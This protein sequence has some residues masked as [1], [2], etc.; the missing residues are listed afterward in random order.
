MALLADR[1]MGG[2]PLILASFF[3]LLGA[4]GAQVALYVAISRTKQ[5]WFDAFLDAT[6]ACDPATAIKQLQTH[7]VPSFWRSFIFWKP[8]SP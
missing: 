7:P 4:Y 5:Y 8:L 2:D 6:R 1:R 3:I